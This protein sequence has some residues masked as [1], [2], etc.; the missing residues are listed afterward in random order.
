MQGRSERQISLKRMLWMTWALGL[1]LRS[2]RKGTGLA[3]HS[4]ISAA[5]LLRTVPFSNK[6]EYL[7]F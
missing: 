6:Q 4:V 2:S 7:L 1:K 3:T 5:T